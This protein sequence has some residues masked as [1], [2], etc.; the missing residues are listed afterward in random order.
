MRKSAVKHSTTIAD[1]LHGKSEHTTALFSHFVAKYRTIG[2]IEII[3]AKTMIGIATPRKRIAYVTQLG[4]NFIHVV[5]SFKIPYRENLCFQK[6]AQVPGDEQ[7]NHHLRIL[8]KED[9]N[10]EVMRFM[11]LAYEQGS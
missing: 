10:T 2:S 7:Y 4:K 3:P 8:H 6:I 5:F 1:F 11:K 9:I